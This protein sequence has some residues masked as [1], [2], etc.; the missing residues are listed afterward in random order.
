MAGRESRQ[1]RR[2]L[3]AAVTLAIV[4][5]GW[6]AS[7]RA[8]VTIELAPDAAN[9]LTAHG[10]KPDGV[11][12][13]LQTDFNKGLEALGKTNA[14]AKDLFDS[15]QTIRIV[16]LG[17]K[18]AMDAGLAEESGIFGGGAQT[19]GDFD[20]AGKPKKAG[21]A[22]IAIDCGQ[23]RQNG[24][25]TPVVDIDPNSTLYRVLIHELLHATNSARKHPPD[26]LEIY[27]AF[28][29]DF[30]KALGHT[31]A[32]LPSAGP[33]STRTA[34][35]T[36][37]FFG[38]GGA[39]VAENQTVLPIDRLYA[40]FSRSTDGSFAFNQTTLGFEKTFLDGQASIGMRLPFQQDSFGGSVSPVTLGDLSIIAKYAFLNGLPNQVASLG[41]GVT[42]PTAGSGGST[43]LQPY[44]AWAWQPT[45]PG[46]ISVSN[47]FSPG[48]FI[49]GFH[50]LLVPLGDSA[51]G[52]RVLTNSAGIGFWLDGSQIPLAPVT[53][54]IPTLE[55]NLRTP[56]DLPRDSNLN[57][58][59][60]ANLQI[61]GG[62]LLG[63]SV[64]VPLTGPK[65]FDT[66][67]TISFNF[68]F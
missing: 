59:A 46:T 52:N 15:G 49:E 53:A 6:S 39:E 51:S 18:E 33:G 50:S 60:G 36:I 27:E 20:A 44:F 57:L 61:A 37:P 56:L 25:R 38:D 5:L 45:A 32:Q 40:G 48:L 16:C 7:A 66:E 55:L 10:D 31:V 62:A 11:T 34:L 68:H 21:K 17:T 30:E 26:D 9:A 35:G 8:A 14:G 63:L 4:A 54:I 22:I 2:S 1:A 12:K 67:A 43:E 58:T 42:L 64:A 13:D 19:K 29:R 3:L 23:L 28:V 41:L 65:P 24:L 47:G